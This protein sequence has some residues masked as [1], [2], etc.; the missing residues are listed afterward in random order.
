MLEDF[1]MLLL[2]GVAAFVVGYVFCTALE[3]KRFI[4]RQY[5]NRWIE[6]WSP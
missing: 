5:G 3:R 6:A 2:V 1:T 4:R